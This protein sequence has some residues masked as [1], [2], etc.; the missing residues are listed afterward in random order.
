MTNYYP[1]AGRCRGC[2]DRDKDC[3]SLP[4]NTMPAHRSDGADVVVICTQFRPRAEE[5]ATR[6]PKRRAYIAGP[7]T[8]LPDFNYPAFH[9]EAAR[10][11]KLGYHV[12]NPAEKKEQP[13]WA[14]YM[15]QA[16]TYMLTC[17]IVALLPG[18]TESRGATLERYIAQQLGLTIIPAERITARS[19]DYVEH[20]PIPRRETDQ[21]TVQGHHACPSSPAAGR[22]TALCRPVEQRQGNGSESGNAGVLGAV[23]AGG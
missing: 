21:C 18:W 15:R 16:I 12:E 10:L 1:K 8:G 13:T 3:S 2:A 11:R 4:F 20:D 22:S 23:P 19:V 6:A 9:A 14:A 5:K 17:E 7:M